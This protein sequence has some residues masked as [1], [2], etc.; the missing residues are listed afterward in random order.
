MIPAISASVRGIQVAIR[1]SDHWRKMCCWLGQETWRTYLEDA[2][3][4][5]FMSLFRNRWARAFRKKTPMNRANC[6]T[7][8]QAQVER[9]R[10]GSN[11][12]HAFKITMRNRWKV[13]GRGLAFHNFPPADENRGPSCRCDMGRCFCQPF[14]PCRFESV[15]PASFFCIK[16]FSPPNTLLRFPLVSVNPIRS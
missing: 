15:P 8:R 12:N 4:A 10:R 3:I 13:S 9:W 11:Q 14:A 1:L 2:K 6:V 16:T 7:S 5:Y